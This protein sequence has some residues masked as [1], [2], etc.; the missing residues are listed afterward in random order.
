[1]IPIDLETARAIVQQLYPTAVDPLL[2]LELEVTKGT[3]YRP[4]AVYFKFL[5]T[6]YRQL[7]KADVVN[8]SYSILETAKQALMMQKSLDIGDTEIPEGQTVDEL[9]GLLQKLECANC[10]TP[11]GY[12]LG[13]NIY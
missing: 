4:Y 2:S 11:N 10:D 1:M 12:L 13:V 3:N 8:F 6:E 5:I 7:T 9:L